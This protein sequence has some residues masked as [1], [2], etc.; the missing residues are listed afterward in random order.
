[1]GRESSLRPEYQI[2]AYVTL[3]KERVISSNCLC[4]LAK[5]EDE[6]K[7]L[8]ADVAKAMK[9]DVTKLTNGDYVIIRV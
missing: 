2:L 7:I 3:A 1:M 5:S 6:A 4:L 9:A 8:T